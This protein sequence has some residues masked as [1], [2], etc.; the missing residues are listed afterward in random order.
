MIG[1]ELFALKQAHPRTD[2]TD[3][4]EVEVPTSLQ[5]DPIDLP[6]GDPDDLPAGQQQRRPEI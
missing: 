1:R 5:R 4:P 2:P 6:E 3:L